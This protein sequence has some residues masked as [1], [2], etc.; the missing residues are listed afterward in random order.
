MEPLIYLLRAHSLS[1]HFLSFRIPG[2]LCCFSV[3]SLVPASPPAVFAGLHP[4][5]GF[6]ERS[7]PRHDHAIH[8]GFRIPASGGPVSSDDGNRTAR[9]SASGPQSLFFGSV[10]HAVDGQNDDPRISLYLPLYMGIGAHDI[11]IGGRKA[12]NFRCRGI[13]THPFADGLHSKNRNRPFF[14]DIFALPGSGNRR[15]AKKAVLPIH[16]LDISGRIFT[17]SVVLVRVFAVS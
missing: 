5:S 15:S 3:P 8:F 4:A 6:L 7:C 12:S 2:E 9:H 16:R 11:C 13:S 10:C 1:S 14:R 17:L